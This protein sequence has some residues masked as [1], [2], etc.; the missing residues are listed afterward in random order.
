MPGSSIAIL[1]F[2]NLSNDPEQE[3]FGDGLAEEIINALTQIQGL[4]VTARTSSFAFKGQAIDIRQIGR[5]LGVANVLEGSIRIA[6]QRV[7]IT[8][9]LINVADGYHLWSENYDRLLDDIFVVQDEIS[10]LI[11]DRIR[12]NSAHFEIADQ[13]VPIPQVDT[14]EYQQF[15]QARFQIQKFN[16]DDVLKGIQMLEALSQRQPNFVAPL[17]QLGLAYIFMGAFGVLPSVQAFDQARHY[18]GKVPEKERGQAEYQLRLAGLIYWQ[19][20]DLPAAYALLQKVLLKQPGHAEAHLWAGVCMAT[21]EQFLVAHD[22]LDTALKLDPFSP[23]MHDFKGAAF[24]FEGQYE[25]AIAYFRRCLSLDPNFHMSHVNWAAAELMQGDIQAGLQRF[26]NLPPSG[27]SD[28]S[29]LGGVTLAQAMTGESEMVMEGIRQLEAALDSPLADRAYFF[30]ILIHTTLEA[31]EKALDVLA[32]AVRKRVSMV[33]MLLLEPFLSPLRKHPRFAVI[34]KEIQRQPD[35]VLP[36]TPLKLS[37]ADEE[38]MRKLEALMQKQTPYLDAQLSLRKLAALAGH[39]PNYLSRLINECTGHNFAE[40]TNSFRLAA[41][42]EKAQNPENQKLTLLA[43]AYECGFNSKT[44][45][46]TYC[47][48]ATG[49]TPSAYWKS[50]TA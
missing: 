30:L 26:Q 47:K 19:E 6:G 37:P 35:P 24:Y 9:Q 27:L 1:P 28:L 49:L 38:D 4:Q 8:A 20:W 21:M 23:L 12:E 33:V 11:A 32:V 43:L 29:T 36:T 31:Y 40:Y 50:L 45:F 17:L 41:F 46:N 22:H 2:V 10:L 48:K 39:H 3:Y 34:L 14:A 15:L 16:R 5:E 18:L 7:R 13:L 25:K 44:V 42:A